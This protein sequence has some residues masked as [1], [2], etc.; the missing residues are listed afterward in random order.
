MRIKYKLTI[1]SILSTNTKY[2]Q[3]QYLEYKYKE[4]I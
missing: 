1:K 3:Q 2:F 4:S